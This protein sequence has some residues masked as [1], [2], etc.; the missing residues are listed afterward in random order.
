MTDADDHSGEIASAIPPVNPK[1][2]TL[3]HNAFLAQL[4]MDDVDLGQ[5]TPNA[6]RGHAVFSLLATDGPVGQVPGAIPL[7]NNVPVPWYDIQDL[8]QVVCAK[9]E[10][11]ERGTR[12][13]LIKR[14]G[15][16]S[17][18]SEE[19]DEEMTLPDPVVTLVDCL[20]YAHHGHQD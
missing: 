19:G 10:G 14:P 6:S 13:D 2:L 18:W 16:T 15:K 8:Q 12:L 7:P 20:H 4:L 17:I 9:A 3:K 11:I 5:S 1:L